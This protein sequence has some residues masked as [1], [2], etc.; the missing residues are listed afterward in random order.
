M[1]LPARMLPGAV[2][3]AI[4]LAVLVGLWLWPPYSVPVATATAV[5]DIW[6]LPPAP[7]PLDVDRAAVSA[8]RVWARSG[9]G[10]PAA[11]AP[12]EALTPPDWRVSGVYARG[13]QSAIIVSVPGRPD[14][15]LEVGAL[16]PGGA[17]IATISPDRICIVLNGKRLSL[18]IHRE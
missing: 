2:A 9:P 7:L 5:P 1:T 11:V 8:S 6:R 12:E 4:L 10:L 13:A 15:T 14:E 18:S 17:R 3:G 16:L